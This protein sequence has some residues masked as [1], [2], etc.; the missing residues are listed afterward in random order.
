GAIEAIWCVQAMRHNVIPPTIN[1]H[2][3]DPDCPIDCVPNVARSAAI[4]VTL[5]SAYG[6]GGHNSTLVF[7]KVN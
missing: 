6:F 7:R 4:N 5:S 2:T 3:P 1:Y